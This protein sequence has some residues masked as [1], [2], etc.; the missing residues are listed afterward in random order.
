MM[1][2]LAP[3]ATEM[4]GPIAST[5]SWLRFRRSRPSSPRSTP[6]SMRYAPSGSRA[7]AWSPPGWPGSATARACSGRSRAGTSSG[8]NAVLGAA[9][10]RRWTAGAGSTAGRRAA[11]RRLMDGTKQAE[12]LGGGD[13]RPDPAGALGLVQQPGECVVQMC[14]RGRQPSVHVDADS[15]QR[16]GRGAVAAAGVAEGEHELEEV[17]VVRGRRRSR[18]AT[19]P[20]PGGS[21]RTAFP[22][23]GSAGRRCRRRRRRRGRCRRSGPR[24]HHRQAPS[25]P[26]PG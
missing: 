19:R 13:V 5:R 14:A 7:P 26:R 2:L 25:G 6:R 16:L 18:S 9:R 3:L 21:L 22:W 17:G 1:W 20:G 8:L 24:V 12:Q 11:A 23:W 4:Q 15:G 10:R